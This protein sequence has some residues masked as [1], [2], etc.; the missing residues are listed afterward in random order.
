LGEAVVGRGSFDSIVTKRILLVR[1]GRS[2]H[3]HDG[4]WM[5]ANRVR[6]YERGYNA[7]GILSEDA[8]PTHL[9]DTATRSD[10]LVASDLRRAIESARRLAPGRDPVILPLLREIDLEPPRWIPMSLPIAAWDALSFAQWSYRLSVDADHEFVRRAD[11]ASDW[12]VERAKNAM[13]VVAVTHGGFRR[14]LAR[15]LEV[16]GWRAA[17]RDLGHANWSAWSF[18]Q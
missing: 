4:A 3:V 1:H 16:R 5:P 11:A 15:R 12:L 8:P 18:T 2:A 9:V 7:A 6:D 13:S 14:I 17:G 10:T